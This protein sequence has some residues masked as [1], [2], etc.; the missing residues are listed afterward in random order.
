[1]LLSCTVTAATV[2]VVLVYDSSDGNCTQKVNGTSAL[3]VDVPSGSSISWTA[4]TK[5]HG[6]ETPATAFDIQF[7]PG[8]SP[9]YDY[10]SPRGTAVVSGPT[11]GTN[12]T[13]HRYSTV[14][15]NGKD[16]NNEHSLGLIMR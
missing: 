11:T 4:V 5:A 6:T 2:N 10:N 8:G 3:L 7:S 12:G 16:C 14:T 13:K 1:M 15:V 9:F